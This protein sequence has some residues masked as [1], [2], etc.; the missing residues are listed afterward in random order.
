MPKKRRRVVW[1]P[2]AKRDV[3]EYYERVASVEIADK[4][5]RE[6][7][8]AAEHLTDAA[9]MWKARDDLMRGLRSVLVHPYIIFYRVTDGVVEI[10]LVLHGRRNFARVF[11]EKEL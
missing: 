8:G 2:K 3:W 6:I 10:A 11:S 4:L 5:L 9:L 1:A 7:D